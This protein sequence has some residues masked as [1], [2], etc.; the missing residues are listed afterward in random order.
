MKNILIQARHLFD[1]HFARVGS[2]G[3]HRVSY[4]RGPESDS[5]VIF[6]GR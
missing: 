6:A 3:S 5:S 1:V 2:V 4:V